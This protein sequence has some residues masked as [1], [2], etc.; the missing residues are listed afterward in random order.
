M[1]NT[2]LELANQS[3]ALS[4]QAP[5][6]ADMMQ[7]MIEK[8][9]TQENVAAFKELVVL[10]EHMEDRNAKREFASAFHAMQKDIPTIKAMRAVPDKQGGV[11][12]K[13]APYSDIMDQ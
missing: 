7:A 4:R 13:Y 5:S 8:G 9:V 3:Q 12:Y 1:K 2:E 6:P 11:K 10:S